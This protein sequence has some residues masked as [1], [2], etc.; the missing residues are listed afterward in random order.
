MEE[1]AC[2]FFIAVMALLGAEETVF[3][4]GGRSHDAHMTPHVVARNLHCTQAQ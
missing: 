3:W 2:M 1:E 4:E